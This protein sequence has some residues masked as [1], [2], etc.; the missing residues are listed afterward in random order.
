MFG[1]SERTARRTVRQA[2]ASGVLA[3]P[4][5]WYQTVDHV[6]DSTRTNQPRLPH[7]PGPA[8]GVS[9]F[10]LSDRRVDRRRML[11]LLQGG[12]HRYSEVTSILC[13]E[14]GCCSSTARSNLNHAIAYG[15]VECVPGGYRLTQEAIRGLEKFGRLEGTEGAMFARFCGGRPGLARHRGP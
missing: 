9:T 11:R 8:R 4:G 7:S 12:E 15:Y 6:V 14:F 1:C 2:L 13:G 3:N 10:A 5:G